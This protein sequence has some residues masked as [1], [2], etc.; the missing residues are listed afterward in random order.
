LEN[1]IRGLESQEELL[2]KLVSA[3]SSVSHT[4]KSEPSLLTSSTSQKAS[5]SFDDNEKLK[6]PENYYR[7]L[8]LLNIATIVE[9]LIDFIGDPDT[10]MMNLNLQ[11]KSR[12]LLVL[13]SSLSSAKKGDISTESCPAVAFR[14]LKASCEIFKSQR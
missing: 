14:R 11:Q 3:F 12:L 7:W 9:G 6:G 8:Q 4:G 10:A 1:R 13:R 5:Y 2:T